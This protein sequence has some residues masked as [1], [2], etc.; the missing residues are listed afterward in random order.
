MS[1]LFDFNGDEV[2]LWNDSP[3]NL[4]S[5]AHRGLSAVAPE[6]TIPAYKLA[7]T[8]GFRYVECD[9]AFT[10]DGVPVLLHDTTIDR[11][12]DGSGNITTLTYAQ[13]M[14]YDFG[15]WKSSEYAGTK[16]PTLSEFASVCKNLALHPYVEIKSAATYSESQIHDIV[17]IMYSY[18]LRNNVTFISGTQAY[19]SYVHEY[20]PKARLG[21]VNGLGASYDYQ[22]VL[23]ICKGLRGTENEVFSDMSINTVTQTIVDAYMSERIPLEVWTVD[24]A[25]VVKSMNPYI[26]GV[27]SNSILADKIL[28]DS[29]F[30]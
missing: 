7:K 10:A 15:S 9:V 19:L 27:T 2:Y 20:D 29:E 13:L 1:Q 24:S 4:R 8:H 14:S 21:F 17:D 6:N 23:N 11:T 18:G 22:Q 25:D 3:S 12:S 30:E 5:V 28:Y 16:I 26:S